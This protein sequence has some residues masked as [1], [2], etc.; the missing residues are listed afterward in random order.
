MENVITSSKSL[1][2]LL[3]RQKTSHISTSKAWTSSEIAALTVG[4]IFGVILATSLVYLKMR[5]IE[6]SVFERVMEELRSAPEFRGAGLGTRGGQG[7]TPPRHDG[8]LRGQNA[9]RCAP[10]GSPAARQ[11]NRSRRLLSLVSENYRRLRGRNAGTIVDLIDPRQ[12]RPQHDI[13]AGLGFLPRRIFRL[14]VPA[15]HWLQGYV[16]R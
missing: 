1:K 5:T 13:A 2:Q 4:T 8:R 7:P 3:S 12:L 10:M 15:L 9:D 6:Q 16:P 11:P 14:N